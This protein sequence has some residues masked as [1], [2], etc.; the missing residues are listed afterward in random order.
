MSS[1]TIEIEFDGQTINELKNKIMEIK[2]TNKEYI[3][4]IFAGQI[5]DNDRTLE[6]YKINNNTVIHCLIRKPINP[7]QN[8]SNTIPSTPSNINNIPNLQTGMFNS[9]QLMNS[10]QSLNFTSGNAMPNNEQMQQLL[11]I[12]NSEQMQQL[13]NIIIQNPEMK[14]MLI[15]MT[16]QS[17]NIPLDSPMRS[18]YEQMLT[19]MFSNPNGFINIYNGS[20]TQ[21][22]MNIFNTMNI[23]PSEVAAESNQQEQEQETTIEETLTE[24]V[25]TSTTEN[26][27]NVNTSS[28]LNEKYAVQIEQIKNMGFDD[29]EKIIEI[30]AQSNGS[31]SIALNKLFN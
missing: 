17:M 21:G 29:E 13:L 10:L 6:S 31:V 4:I 15:N 5:L 30:L 7:T 9:E 27:D 23:H 11:N 18:T 20:N 24:S 3:K 19:T 2:E 26:E 16:L 12:I 28:N 25:T 22:M 8:E 1:E 14:E